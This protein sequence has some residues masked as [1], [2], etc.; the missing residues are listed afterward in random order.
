MEAKNADVD[1]V[2]VAACGER[3]GEVV[4]VLTEFRSLTD[5]RTGRS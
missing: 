5:P 1:V 2:I 3:A 4:E